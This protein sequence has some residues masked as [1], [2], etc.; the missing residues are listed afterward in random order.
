MIR[1]VEVLT[2]MVTCDLV[3][4]DPGEAFL[5]RS[6]ITFVPGG[7]S[8]TVH[9]VGVPDYIEDGP[10][11]FSVGISK[12]SS[13]NLNY[14]FSEYRA[15]GQSWNLDVPFPKIVSLEPSSSSMVGQQVTIQ[16]LD[17]LN[18]T[19]VYVSGCLISGPPVLRSTLRLSDASYEVLQTA[20]A[21]GSLLLG[22]AILRL[23][24]ARPLYADRIYGRQRLCIPGKLRI[25]SSPKRRCAQL[26]TTS[27]HIS[28][29]FSAQSDLP[30][31]ALSSI[32]QFEWQCILTRW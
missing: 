7:H 32:G 10:Q 6:T 19:Q 23:L 16:G 18:D 3:V 25:S 9:I 2:S 29:K 28:F 13:S 17:L 5:D 22:V 15:I 21:P 20:L 24:P 14:D 4:S 31:P 27:S 30:A 12:C 1:P 26:P 11:P 8:Q